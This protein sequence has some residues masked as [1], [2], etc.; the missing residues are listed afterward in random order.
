MGSRTIEV[1]GGNMNAIQLD[2]K[3]S[4]KS[5]INYR[6]SRNYLD[7]ASDIGTDNDWI[8]FWEINHEPKRRNKLFPTDINRFYYIWHNESTD[9]HNLYGPATIE[10]YNDD[11]F[12][13]E[14][15]VE[16]W[17]DCEIY[18]KEEWGVQRLKHPTFRTPR[19]SYE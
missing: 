2:T 17:I 15:N 13:E 4:I 5:G 11:D 14:G 12:F 3:F 10:I 9:F 1:H 8:S 6:R 19:S 16:Y 7:K 18:S